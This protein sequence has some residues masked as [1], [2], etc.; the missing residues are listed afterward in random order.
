MLDGVSGGSE[1]GWAYHIVDALSAH[2]DVKLYVL[3]GI[4]KSEK[5]FSSNVTLIRLDHGTI[6]NLTPGYTLAFIARYYAAA[7]RVLR[8][9]HIDVIHHILPFG[10]GKTFNPLPL[11][12][13]TRSTPFIVGPLQSPHTVDAPEERIYSQGDTRQ[14]R[15]ISHYIQEK[16]GRRL[17]NSGAPILN[18]L[19]SRTLQRSDYLIAVNDQA[20]QLYAASAPHTPSIIIPPGVDLARFADIRTMERPDSDVEI[21]YVGWLIRRKGIDIIIDA[22]SQLVPEFPFLRLRIVG[23]GPQRQALE[24]LVQRRDLS[25]HVIFEGT[26]AN[27]AIADYYAR[28]SLFVSMSYSESFGQSLVEAMLAGLPVVS[29][30]NIGSREIIEESKTGFL[31][32]AGDTKGLVVRLK[33]LI[34]NPQLRSEIGT[35]AR[36]SAERRYD[37]NLI[38]QQY[39]DVYRQALLAHVDHAHSMP[40]A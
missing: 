17:I 32:Q 5:S 38:G 1:Y 39:L 10:Y 37:W 23:D 20:R 16:A 4:V 22:L 9:H 6:L 26:I 40:I 35:R 21:L 13:Q 33:A 31:V 19:S 2:P 28:A 11:F 8:Q 3:T 29:A 24:A 30:E 36:R 15:G 14:Y 7:C 12:G 18:R 27:A 25:K 34:I